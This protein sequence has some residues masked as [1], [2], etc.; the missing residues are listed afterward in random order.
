MRLMSRPTVLR[1]LSP[2]DLRA[3]QAYRNDPIVAEFQSWEA[4]DDARAHGFLSH[5]SVTEPLINPGEWAQIAVADADTDALLGDIGLHLSTDQSVAEL[6]ITLARAAQGKGHATRAVA[7]AVD[8][9]FDTTPITRINAWADIRN[10]PSCRLM[11][12][13]GFTQSGIEVTNGITEAVF[14]LNRPKM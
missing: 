6:G 2:D 10:T 13:A 8:L 12:R 4:M 14:V 5:V 1:R 7:M 11:V 3:F 9:L